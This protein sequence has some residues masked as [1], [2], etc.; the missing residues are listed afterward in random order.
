[1]WEKSQKL[2]SHK[3]KYVTQ[4]KHNILQ[5]NNLQLNLIFYN[6]HANKS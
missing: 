6:R 3:A 5:H 4:L 1:M 2:S